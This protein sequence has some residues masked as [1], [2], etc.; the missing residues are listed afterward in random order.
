MTD[1]GD[2]KRLNIY[3]DETLIAKAMNHLKYVDPDNATREDAVSLLAFMQTIA[4]QAP[5]HIS[6]ASFDES[7]KAYK[8]QQPKK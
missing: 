2:F 3:E 4:Q 7:Y 5:Q 8:E 1:Q 6:A